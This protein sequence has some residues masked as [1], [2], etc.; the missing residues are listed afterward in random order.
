[1]M[2]AF[3][4]QS[5]PK[6]IVQRVRFRSTSEPP[7]KELPPPPMPKAPESPASLPECRSTRKIRTTEMITSTTLST[8]AMGGSVGAPQRW[9]AARSRSIRLRISIASARSSASSRRKSS[10]VS[11]PAAW[12]AS[13]SR[14]WRYLARLRA[15]RSASSA[16]AGSSG[17][18]DGRRRSGSATNHATSS[19]T[20]TAS[21]IS[22]R[23]SAGRR[24]GPQLA[25]QPGAVGRLE[26][27]A[28][29]ER[30]PPRHHGAGECDQ[31]AD[32][33]PADKRVDDHPEVGGR[34]VVDVVLDQRQDRELLG[35]RREVGEL[36]VAALDVW[37]EHREVG[38]EGRPEIAAGARAQPDLAGRLAHE[39]TADRAGGR[40]VGWV[41]V[42]RRREGR[43]VLAVAAHVEVG[44][45][46][47]PFRVRVG[48]ELVV[49]DRVV[50]DLGALADLEA[51]VAIGLEARGGGDP[52]Q[53]Q[54]DSR[55]D[56]VAAVTA[57][58]SAQRTSE[59]A[60][61]WLAGERPSRRTRAPELA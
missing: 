43:E 3:S 50:A 16:S 39:V 14:I 49:A 52:D 44:D 37:V 10:S 40:I 5:T 2:I 19:T 30:G 45:E 27:A 57:A 13:A 55:V 4:A 61:V 41:V 26:A 1:M 7:P 42:P 25:P 23:P 18:A 51:E 35:G 56:H 32:P 20:A 21:R 28:R 38:L 59:R 33:D 54:S 34:R 31:R 24:R 36:A 12:S 46:G 47:E 29:L 58:V 48:G 15:S 53:G 6:K 60:G 9:P 17:S 22:I 11:L 8:V